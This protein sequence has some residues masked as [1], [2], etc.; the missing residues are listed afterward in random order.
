MEELAQADDFGLV[1]DIQEAFS[2]FYVGSPMH[3]DLGLSMADTVGAQ[4]SAWE[5]RALARCTEGLGAVLL[6]LRR[7]PVVRYDG[8]SAMAAR[9]A[10]DV[11]QLMERE[12][13]VFDFR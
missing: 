1:K 7:K 3:F 11:C 4:L 13:R 5:P 2:D 9:L 8:G 12:S 6:A 10:H